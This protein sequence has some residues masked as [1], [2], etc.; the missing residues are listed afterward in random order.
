[1][2][3]VQDR[4]TTADDLARV[5]STDQALTARLIRLSNSAELAFGRRCST[6]KEAVHLL[7]FL[8]VRQVAVASSLMGLFDGTIADE[9]AFDSDLFW[10]HSL[11]VA[12]AA[13]MVARSTGKARPDDAFTAGI[14]HDIGRLVIRRAFP[15]DF[16]DA[17]QLALDTG[18]PI[19]EAE[20]TTTGYSHE[21]VGRALARYWQFPP[22]LVSAIANHHDESL[23]ID[24]H[25]LRGIVAIADRLVL[26]AGITCGYYGEQSGP[27][28]LDAELEEAERL[29]GGMAT[30]LS[31]A[32]WYM[33]G[34]LRTP[35]RPRVAT[36]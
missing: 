13:E 29:A 12:V 9:T 18:V 23:T 1:M 30:V 28:P 27:R 3:L 6:V 21:R 8:Q 16:R 19:H 34:A 24:E 25:G 31:R 17:G 20:L 7:G 2:A 15:D 10:A 11:T 35:S 5:V 36:A 14:L 26:R 32:A 33:E 4:R 22:H